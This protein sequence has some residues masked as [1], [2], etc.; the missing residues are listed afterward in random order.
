GGAPLPGGVRHRLAASCTP[1]H[2]RRFDRPRVLRG[3]RGAW[4]AP[5]A[6]A[7]ATQDG[8]ARGARRGACSG[9][10]RPTRDWNRRRGGG[11]GWSWRK[12]VPRPAEPARQNVRSVV[13]GLSGHL[14]ELA[15][16]PSSLG[17]C[18]VVADEARE[19]GP[20]G[21]RVARAQLQLALLP[22]R[23][24]GFVALRVV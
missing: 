11:V 20:R 13:R 12:T 8:S 24:R 15:P 14:G 5:P 18:R 22:E 19:A 10:N 7:V 23:G 9:D 1:P 6:R 21:G 3:A 4:R 17:R 16:G 2:R